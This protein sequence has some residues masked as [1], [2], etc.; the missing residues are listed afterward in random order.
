MNKQKEKL[1]ER[2]DLLSLEEKNA[3]EQI[4]QR[5]KSECNWMV[6]PYVFIQLVTLTAFLFIGISIVAEIP[7]SIFAEGFLSMVGAFMIA[8]P[9]LM[10]IG[11]IYNIIGRYKTNK[12][13]KKLLE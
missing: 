12:L 3:Y 4:I 9:I 1:Q 10:F 2:Y 7:V 5:N 6:L 13:K 11:I 8:I